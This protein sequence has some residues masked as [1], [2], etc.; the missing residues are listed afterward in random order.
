MT[1]M[2]AQRT[3]Q[4]L[5]DALMAILRE[6]PYE[7]ITVREVITRTQVSR[8]SFYNHYDG[9]DHLVQD[10]FLQVSIYFRAPQKRLRDYACRSDAV[11]ETLNEWAHTLVLF[12][13]NPNFAR[14]ILD[15]IC[16]SRYFAKSRHAEEELLLDHLETEYAGMPRPA[17]LVE[18]NFARYI[19]WGM[20]GNVRAWFMQGMRRPIEDVVKEN[21]YCAL[22]STAGLAGHPIE[23]EYRVA[24]EAWR[25]DDP[26]CEA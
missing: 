2:R 8:N 21:I 1:D 9:L 15:S 26:V 24:I 20:F 19:V 6:K 10:C 4:Y 14:V 12:R 23:P 25:F 22:Q 11:T 16:T 18:E 17:F 13:D 5:R 3:R 7:A